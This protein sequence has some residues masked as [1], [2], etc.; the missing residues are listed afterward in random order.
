MKK[1]AVGGPL[2][3]NLGN[4]ENKQIEKQA[5]IKKALEKH[6][7]KEI[8]DIAIKT[9][10][11]KMEQKLLILKSSSTFGGPLNVNLG[12][13]K[14]KQ[15]EKQAPIKKALEKQTKKEIKH[16]SYSNICKENGTKTPDIKSS[17]TSASNTA[18]E[19]KQITNLQK[20]K[21]RIQSKNEV[22]T[23]EK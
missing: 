12:N 4:D 5:P 1:S 3:I 14:N 11:K 7:K 20:I 22:S 19:K 8:Q 18:K 16:S 10:Q 6:T 2:N 15:I 13:D 9:L 21:A 17:N 23:F